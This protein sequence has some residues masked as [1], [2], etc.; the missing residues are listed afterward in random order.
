M[1][2]TVGSLVRVRGREWVVLPESTDELVR[3]RPLGGTDDEVTGVYTLLESVEPAQFALPDPT[4]IGDYRS[5]R[6]LRAAVRLGFRSSAGP[7]RSFARINVEPRP[8]QLVPLL[9]ALKQDPVRLLIADDVGIGKT[10]EALLV[11]RELLDRGEIDRLAVLCPPPLAE[12]W[13]AELRDKFYIEAELVLSSTATRL[14]R[15]LQMGESLFERHPFVVV[16]TDFIKSER[17]RNEFLRTAPNFIIVDEAH[18]VA[19]TTDQRGGKH[20]RHELV[21]ALAEKAERHLILVTATPHSGKEEA[22][23]SLLAMLNP[24][25]KNLPDDLTGA[26]NEPL[27]RE[28]AR[29][30][31][32][33]RRGDIRAYMDA[34]TPFPE[35]DTDEPTYKLTDAY[36]RLFDRVLDYARETVRQPGEGYRQRV[37]W[38]SALAL[39]RSLAS[40]PAAAA[41]TLRSRAATTEADNEADVDDIGRRTVLDLM[42]DESAEGIDVIPG[43]DTSELEADEDR[44]RHR[45]LAM[46][47]EAEA[48]Q[49]EGDSKL[50]QLITIVKDLLSEGYSPIVFCRFIPT[51][52]YVTDALREAARGVEI[53]GVTGTLPPAEREER[54]SQLSHASKRVL[55][56]TD[57]LSE[58][59]N[60]QQSFDAVVHYDLSW[61]PTRHEQREGRVDRYGQP[62]SRI[63]VVTYYGIDNQIDGIVLDVLLRKH[64]TIRNSLGISVPVPGNSEDVVEAIFE[65]L[66]LREN[67]SSNQSVLPG[68][69]AYMKPR[70]AKLNLQWEAAAEREKRSRTMFAQQA[71]RVDE[72]AA[73]LNAA[74]EAVG[75]GVDVAAFMKDAVQ[76]HRGVVSESGAVSFDL[77]ETPRGLRDMLGTEKFVARFELPVREG[78]LY[79]TRTHPLVESLA[80]YV[81][82][83]ALDAVDLEEHQPRARRAG[84]IRTTAVQRRTT[85]LLVRFRYH[86]ITRIG[87]EERQLLAEDS[88][89]LAFEGAPENAAWLEPSD[90]ERL[91]QAEPTEN[92][93]PQQAAEFVQRVVDGFDHIAPTLN[94]IA[95]QRGDDLLAAHV[96]VRE[97][98]YRHGERRPQYRVEAQLPPDVL[99]LYVFLPV[100]RK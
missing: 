49:G 66:L 42:T 86:L 20:Q 92:I 94:D 2:F 80:T 57:C 7:F 10:V 29:Y 48:L 76:M 91:L 15:H 95:R 93:H 53:I 19:H 33:R 59:I 41:A 40:S 87:S 9:M 70:Q 71:I 31:V 12:Q 90:A 56:C 16:S 22:F 3:L 32:Q 1:S 69:E 77:T 4:Q 37:R 8:Y 85:L 67:A 97:A 25:F 28:L 5:A 54:V 84:A 79:L 35:R 39:L 44:H 11:A 45:L 89:T 51:V 98:A 65:G 62:S 60:L 58:G 26:E 46:A 14:E 6:L 27:R 72:V 96:R 63:K 78:Q 18:N 17:R 36:K 88:L 61:N 50:Q 82:N 52:E 99:G 13:H 64:K 30:F 81:M 34:I 74:R 68:F 83:T 73:E 38:W 21:A 75:S 100:M 23:R 47:R 43:S 24:D 55:V